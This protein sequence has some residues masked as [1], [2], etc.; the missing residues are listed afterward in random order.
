MSLYDERG[1]EEMTPT[2]KALYF[3]WDLL[4]VVVVSLLIIL[5]VRYWLIQP[6]YVKGASMEPT[7]YDHEYLIINEIVYQV[8]TPHR[9]DVI[10]F[11]YPKDPSQYFIKRVIGLPGERVE[12]ADNHVYIYPANSSTKFILDESPY[13]ASTVNTVGNNTWTLG[14]NEYF[15]VGDNRNFSLDSRSFGPV[16]K[17]LI[18]GKVW[19]RGW[20][21]WR[22]G[23]FSTINYA[24][25][26]LT[27]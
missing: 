10:V 9:G 21:V 15:V 8:G 27:Q 7:F 13:L 14:A 18:I 19:V 20:P 2:K 1:E 22:A 11:K 5:P 24:N 25:T 3:I 16:D 4:K 6:F 26:P 12:V 23:V 17:D